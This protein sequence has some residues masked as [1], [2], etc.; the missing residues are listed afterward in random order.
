VPLV[1]ARVCWYA[2]RTHRTSKTNP[3]RLWREAVEG[4][5]RTR[6]PRTTPEEAFEVFA[7]G[8]LVDEVYVLDDVSG[9][10]IAI[11]PDALRAKYRKE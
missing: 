11:A 7:R 6:R 10:C 2:G 3:V 1:P 4:L 8:T 9:K 5:R